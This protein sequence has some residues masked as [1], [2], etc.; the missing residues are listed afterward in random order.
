MQARLE[1]QTGQAGQRFDGLDALRQAAALRTTPALRDEA[2]ALLTLTDL[3]VAHTTPVRATPNH[4]IT[5]DPA[6][7]RYL[8]C[9]PTDNA[10]SLRRLSDHADL[11]TAPGTAKNLLA[12]SPFSADGR[13]V[14]S[15]HYDGPIRVWNTHA[16]HLAFELKQIPPK[17]R[18]YQSVL[19][20]FGC[21]FSHDGTRAAI[22]LSEG[23]YT[24]HHTP[25]GRE[26]ARFPDKPSAYALALSPDGHRL[27]CADRGSTTVEIRDTLT[28]ETRHTLRHLAKIFCLEW[29]PDAT[30]LAI[31]CNDALIHIWNTATG[32]RH[33][34][35][36]AHRNRVTHLA[37]SP[38]GHLLATT[39]QDRNIILWNPR[40]GKKL[41]THPDLGHEP[42]LR[43]S[44]DGKR[45]VTT[46]FQTTAT[47]LEV[48]TDDGITHTLTP[49]GRSHN[50]VVTASLDFSPDAHWLVSSTRR[51][52]SL[53]HL[54]RHRFAATLTPGGDTET[55]ALFT[56]DGAT[57]LVATRD[58]GLARHPFTPATPDAP[59]GPP[60][61]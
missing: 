47:L 59:L 46:N 27:A 29:N 44:R 23:G 38:D 61:S 8:V 16:H 12:L 3:R 4:P 56:P 34:T 48:A 49:P 1:R 50:A 42:V 35:L 13:Y 36:D 11:A 18:P 14:A 40:S 7:E 20:W 2:A 22:E 24:I 10:L 37:F 45:L 58:T 43:F 6:L 30:L 15:R 60:N 39:S 31:G 51:A 17:K 52:I 28:G 55:S 33:R 32:E 54:S 41:V 53:W 19:F 25:T 21:T 5:F 26:L 57:L 9:L